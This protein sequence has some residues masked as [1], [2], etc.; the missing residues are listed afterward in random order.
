MN[1]MLK[2]FWNQLLPVKQQ[3]DNDLLLNV[4][5]GAMI[6]FHLAGGSGNIIAVNGHTGPVVTLDYQDVLAESALDA[7][8]RHAEVLEQLNTRPTS[9][10]LM[11]SL[12][13]YPLLS[14]MQQADAVVLASAQ[15]GIDQQVSRLR[16]ELADTLDNKAD[17]VNGVLPTS[18]LPALAFSQFL[19]EVS[20]QADMLALQ[21]QSGDWCIRSDLGMTYIIITLNNT[22]Q[23]ADWIAL[24]QANG[25]VSTVNGQT[26]VV[27]L[28]YAD[29]GAEQAGAAALLQGS[30]Q[31]QLNN[32]AEAVAVLQALNLKT[33]KATRVL[34]GSGL[35]GGGDL[36]ADCALALA[37]TGVDTGTY[38]KV[39]VNSK[40][41][42]TAGSNLANSDIPAL[43]WSKISTGKPATLSGYGIADAYT[44]LES[45][46]RYPLHQHEHAFSQITARPNTLDG[47][48]ITDA[49][50]GSEVT[51]TPSANKLLRLDTNARLPAD[52]T[53]NAGT[54][55]QLSYSRSIALSGDLSGSAS[56][57]GSADISI[58]T[59]LA[60]S[61][62]TAGTY[63][64]LT[65][66]SQGI[67]TLGTSLSSSDIPALDWS[68]ITTGKPFTLSGY[69]ITDAVNTSDVT[70]TATASKLLKLDMNSKLPADITGSA[71]TAAQLTVARNIALSGA[72]TGS[73]SFDGSASININA[74]LSDSGVAA[75]TFSK[76]TVN[77]KGIVT[78]GTNLLAS[79]IPALDWTKITTGKPATLSGYGITDAQALDATLTALAGLTTSA[80]SLIYATGSDSFTTTPLTSAGRALL[81]DADVVAQRATL[82]LGTAAVVNYGTASGNAMLVG[83]FG[84]G[85][86]NA[87]LMTSAGSGGFD[88]AAGKSQFLRY[89]TTTENRP[90]IIGSAGTGIHIARAS[91]GSNDTQLAF[92]S[93]GKIAG[94]A[95]PSG[96]WSG[97]FSVYTSHNPVAYN[98]TTASAANVVVSSSGEL[99]RSTSSMKYKTDVEPMWSSIAQ[100]LVDQAEPFFYRSLCSADNPQHSWYGLSAEQ[101]ASIDPRFVLWKTHDYVTLGAGE[102]QC[103]QFTELD[104]PEIEGVY[105]ER[106]VVPLLL[107]VKQLKKQVA[108]LEQRLDQLQL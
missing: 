63:T 103:T 98:T 49:I 65:V 73:S 13:A 9:T 82:G 36:S 50:H 2:V 59:T 52:I 19:G 74:T 11:Q 20:S 108:A 86:A 16:T 7:Q 14:T 8:L 29:V 80:D 1:V 46:T 32:K 91:D 51:T 15:S 17:L 38:C 60:N 24:P 100:A 21:G 101:I 27:V 57:D 47:Y 55:D 68:K 53:G 70:S 3:Q 10:E 102:S 34:A 85:S 44:K 107:V 40:G 76:L 97:W 90:G 87:D 69:G 33:D 48:G 77:S 61:G 31:S 62:V 35:S 99:Q 6:P 71:V 43:D 39:S 58:A 5:L 67:V 64:R 56:F 41:V 54:A 104:S 25:A 45:D 4:P 42:V 37:D 96:T 105:Y 12:G 94:R 88:T 89:S 79:D 92:D 66:N 26:G 83:A 93:T 18:Q 28:G 75:G 23:L 78:A 84:L 95:K 106:L 81:D 30:M 22:G 72:L